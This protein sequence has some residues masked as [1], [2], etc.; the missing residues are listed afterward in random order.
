VRQLLPA[1]P[2]RTNP[3]PAPVEYAVAAD[4]YLAQ[5]GL[6]A[7]SRRVYRISLASWAWPLVGK[8]TPRGAGRRGA[9]PIVPLALLDE[10]GAGLRLTVAVAD[11]AATAG[12]RTVNRELS[13]LR[14]AVAWWQDQRWIRGDPTAG[15][16][17]LPGPRPAPGP[18]TASQVSQLFRLRSGLREHAFW[19]LLYD[20]GAPA[21]ELLSLD[22]GGLDL[23]HR[24]G[25]VAAPRPGTW[26][27]WTAASTSDLL[28]WLVAGRPEG[29]VFVT[30]RR[31]PGHTARADRCPVTGR[32][33]MS[34]R[35]AAE[36][37]T[38]ATVPLD[39]AGRGWTLH[40][41]QQAG[42]LARGQA[43]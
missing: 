41:L 7:A 13:A 6:G 26:I 34:Y 8:P 5:A 4:R 19:Q 1:T 39:P 28:G 3:G 35:R 30:G 32:A 36:L 40:Q 9:P 20:T 2:P 10:P 14:G 31:A 23:A 22:I 37:F 25:R 33:R 21:A 12:A 42:R 27:C 11:R 16:R 29:P 38:A 17:H 15:L 24:R 43:R 18:L